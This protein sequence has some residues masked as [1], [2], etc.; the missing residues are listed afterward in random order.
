MIDLSRDRQARARSPCCRTLDKEWLEDTSSAVIAPLQRSR[1]RFARRDR[2]C[3]RK[4]TACN[5]R[6]LELATTPRRGQG[7]LPWSSTKSLRRG[8]ARQTSVAVDEACR[9]MRGLWRGSRRHGSR[10]APAG[11]RL[12][13]AAVSALVAGKFRVERRLGAGAMGTAYL[14]RDLALQRPVVVKALSR[15]LAGGTRQLEGEARAMARVADSRLA[16]IFGVETW[17]GAPLL[18]MEYLAGGTLAGSNEKGTARLAR[19][20]RDWTRAGSRPAGPAR[21]R[22][23]PPRCEANEYS[24]HGG[25]NAETPRF[26]FGKPG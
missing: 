23:P 21:R 9:G 18:V 7:R 19:R 22:R 15:R 1:R 12:R 14:A 2:G 24:V 10:R 11:A 6:K 3:G 20:S 13:T 16:L 17:R 4:A 5:S 8:E 25:W 26:R